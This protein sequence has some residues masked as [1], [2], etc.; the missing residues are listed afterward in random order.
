MITGLTLDD[1]VSDPAGCRA[2]LREANSVVQAF[3]ASRSLDADDIGELHLLASGGFLVR[4][5]RDGVA[6]RLDEVD[7]RRGLTR[8]DTLLER[9]LLS[10][11]AV[12]Q[13]DLS[14]RNQVVATRKAEL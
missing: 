1:R 5:T 2:R 4:T 6:L 7:Y 13:V 10:L 8:L 9:D 3:E 11:V 12:E 14:L